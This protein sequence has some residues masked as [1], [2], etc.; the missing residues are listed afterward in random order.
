MSAAIRHTNRIGHRVRVALAARRM[1]VTALAKSIGVPYR[2]L[3]SY[4][5]A[6]NR[7]PALVV[8]DI[9]KALDVSIDFLLIGRAADLDGVAVQWS[10]RELQEMWPDCFR[11][12]ELD[13]GQA[14]RIFAGGY[15]HHFL[16]LRDLGHAPLEPGLERGQGPAMPLTHPPASKKARG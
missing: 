2:T 10:L 1:T 16:G 12:S 15:H 14:A 5:T 8:A 7:F 13:L 4:L 6:D 3:Q 11:L 9:A